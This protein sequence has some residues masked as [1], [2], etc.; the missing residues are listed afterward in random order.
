MQA[1]EI[2]VPISLFLIVF[3]IFYIYFTT[4]HRER[5]ALIEKGADAS[6]FHT[7]N[8]TGTARKLII[9]N[10]ALELRR[11]RYAVWFN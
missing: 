3:G 1:V 11:K 2:L 10:L 4:R 7:G 8:S 9:L 6:L 5:L